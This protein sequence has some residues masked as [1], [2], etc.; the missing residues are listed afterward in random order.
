LAAALLV[1]P[2]SRI[3]P[4]DPLDPLHLLEVEGDVRPLQHSPPLDDSAVEPF[5]AQL[6]LDQPL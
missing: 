6:A 1:Y 2:L 3:D 4:L 5:L